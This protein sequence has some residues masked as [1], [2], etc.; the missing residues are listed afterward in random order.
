MK[1]NHDMRLSETEKEVLRLLAEA[2]NKYLELNSNE[3]D[4]DSFSAAIHDA[5]YIIAL[6]VARRVNPEVWQ[7]E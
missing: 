5:Q 6:R 4:N 7:Q 2:W 1:K 3:R